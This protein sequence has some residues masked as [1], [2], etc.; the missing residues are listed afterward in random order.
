MELRNDRGG[1][2]MNQLADDSPRQVIGRTFNQRA[3]DL[4]RLGRPICEG[5]FHF[6]PSN[7]RIEHLVIINDGI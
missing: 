7:E 4:D 2:L 6:G 1:V 3:R 5:Q